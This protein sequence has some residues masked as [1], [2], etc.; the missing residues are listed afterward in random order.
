MRILSYNILDGG[1]DRIDALTNVIS[2]ARPDVACLVEADEPAVVGK[3]AGRLKMDFIHAPGNKK[4]SAILSRFPIVETVNHAPLHKELTKSFVE[5]TIEDAS[6][7]QWILGVLHLHAHATEMDEAIREREIEVVLKIFEPRRSSGTPHLLMGDFNAN[8]PY[9]RIDPDRCKPSTRREWAENGGYIPR[10]VIQRVL[11]AGYV[12]SLRA[13]D[14]VASEALG[15]FS[16]QFPRQRVD[17]IFTF[18]ID[19]ALMR[20]ATI[21]QS[22]ASR[23]ASDHF[24]TFVEI[25]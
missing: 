3:I 22:E 2:D 24:P 23:S 18:A 6:G 25:D 17:F 19:P 21:I 11:D 5:A 8:A 9:Q 12:D 7:R 1:A 4:A 14:P 20:A 15:S 10:R 13:V 16:T